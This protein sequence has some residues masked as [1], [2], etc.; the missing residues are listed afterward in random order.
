LIYPDGTT[1]N[2]MFKDHMRDGLGSLQDTKGEFKYGIWK[3][4]K[5]WLEISKE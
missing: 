3:K 4:D 1:Y 5:I 2:G